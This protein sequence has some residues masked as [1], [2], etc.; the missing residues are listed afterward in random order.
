MREIRLTRALAEEEADS[1]AGR[2]LDESSYDLLLREDARVLRPDGSPLLVLRR[3]ALPLAV[4]AAAFPAVRLAARRNDNRGTAGGIIPDSVKRIP[5][6]RAIA[7]RKGVRWLGLKADGTVSRSDRAFVVR[8]G[9]VGYFDRT[10]R[11]PYCRQTAFAIDHPELLPACLDLFRAADRVFAESVP[12]RH[13]A[14]MAWA[15]RISPDFRLTGTSF[16]T[17]TVNQNWQTA[18][19]KDAGD[20]KAGFGV[21]T[22]LRAGPY[23][24]GHLVFPAYRVAV[25]LSTRDVLMSDVHEWHGNTPLAGVPGAF[26][27]ISL[28]LYCR[29]KLV[30]CGSAAEELA[31][32]KARRP[33]TPLNP[34]SA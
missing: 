25:D 10:S 5:G 8:S 14:Q 18:V 21:M 6:A 31:R 16:T 19:H 13:A 15:G 27:R 17:V 30:H 28:V 2:L 22:V 29:E 34:E 1:L 26:E 24:G 12:D 32:A 9:L 11:Y 4:C 33:G 7:S 3:N 23:S 20:L